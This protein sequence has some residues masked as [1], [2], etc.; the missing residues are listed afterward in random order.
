MLQKGGVRFKREGFVLKGM[1]CV[2]KWWVCVV[3]CVCV[4]V[5]KVGVCV[6]KG[7]EGACVF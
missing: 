2:V 1:L 3:E 5:F 7:R 4:C 6:I